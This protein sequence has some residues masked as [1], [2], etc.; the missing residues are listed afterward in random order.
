MLTYKGVNKRS[1]DVTQVQQQRPECPTVTLTWL[2]CKYKG[3][4]RHQ[5]Y[6]PMY[7]RWSLY[8]PCIYILMIVPLVEFMDLVFIRMPGGSYCRRLTILL[9]LCDV[10][11]ALI[12]SLVC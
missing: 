7:H 4:K 5:S 12:N 1:K 9:C 6:I 3:R 8:V 10:F 11:R 2:A